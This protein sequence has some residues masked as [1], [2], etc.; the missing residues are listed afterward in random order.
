MEGRWGKANAITCNEI[1]ERCGNVDN[2]YGNPRIRKEVLALINIDGMTIGGG[3]REGYYLIE[4]KA[5]EVETMDRLASRAESI[6]ERK[7]A[8]R[9]AI[10]R[11]NESRVEEYPPEVPMDQKQMEDF[12]DFEIEHLQED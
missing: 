3:G 8:L 11:E 5:E 4:T 9:N 10:S 2:G 6:R 12:H 1:N 7:T